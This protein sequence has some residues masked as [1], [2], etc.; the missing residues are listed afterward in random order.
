MQ[1]GNQQMPQQGNANFG[2]G[3]MGGAPA[4]TGSAASPAL[5]MLPPDIRAKVAA[6]PPA[7]Q[8]AFLQRFAQDYK[9]MRGAAD[10]MMSMAESLRGSALDAEGRNAGRTYVAAN[11]LEHIARGYQNRKATKMQQEAIDDKKRLAE[12]SGMATQEVLAMMLR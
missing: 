11:P 3:A 6:L 8:A 5:S 4:S 10:D 7:E 9:G 1:Y 2:G 12:D